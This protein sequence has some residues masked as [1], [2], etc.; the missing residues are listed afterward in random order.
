MA[1]IFLG[2]SVLLLGAYTFANRGGDAAKT[3]EKE[4]QNLFSADGAATVDQSGNQTGW[5]DLLSGT[6]T[7]GS[8]EDNSNVTK[9]IARVAFNQ[10]KSLDQQGKSPFDDSTVNTAEVQSAIENSVDG[11]IDSFYGSAVLVSDRELKISANNT[12]AAKIAYLKSIEGILARHQI[13]DEYKN[14]PGGLQTQIETACTNG[15][16]GIN[17]DIAS[18]YAATAKDFIMTRVPLSWTDFHKQAI[19]H[20]RKGN[21]IFSAVSNCIDDP[22]KGLGAAQKLSTF[23]MDAATLQN[24][25]KKMYTE[26]GL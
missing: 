2:A 25:L 22:V 16:P 23:G 6:T 1:A 15:D 26:V 12:K 8:P 14:V 7:S 9:N 19:E 18:V 21:L 3:V 5:G 10:M 20:Y 17:K 4:K 13:K 24:L 11:S